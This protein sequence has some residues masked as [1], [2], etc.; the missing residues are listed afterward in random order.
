MA[1]VSLILNWPSGRVRYSRNP[2]ESL[3]LRISIDDRY[4]KLL[5]KR[6]GRMLSPGTIPSTCLLDFMFYSVALTCNWIHSVIR[7]E[8]RKTKAM[9]GRI[10]S[11][12]GLDSNTWRAALAGS[13]PSFHVFTGFQ[14]DGERYISNHHLRID[15]YSNSYKYYGVMWFVLRHQSP[16]WALNLDKWA[17]EW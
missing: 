16:V 8:S 14:A 13:L 7:F 6:V 1:L 11:Q 10:R 2:S 17:V 3:E 5:N 9:A 12:C 4:E 15:H